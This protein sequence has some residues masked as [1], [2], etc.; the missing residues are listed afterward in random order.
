M[1]KLIY[2]GL[3]WILILLAIH[4][5]CETGAIMTEEHVLIKQ[6]KM[7]EGFRETPYRDPLNHWTVGYGHNIE[8]RDLTITEQQMLFP[9]QKY[10]LSIQSQVDY[11]RKTP[12]SKTDAEYL[13]DQAIKITIHDAIIVFGDYWN[14]IPKE[15]KVP[16]LDMLYNLGRPKFLKFRKCITAIKA[17]DWQEAG[18]QVRNSIAY[19]QAKSRYERIAKEFEK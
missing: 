12:L 8:G 5:A 10:P 1:S 4:A 11:W 7:E 9:D 6:L 19:L 3:L 18:K 14:R 15:K 17:S 16:I 13:L 2:A